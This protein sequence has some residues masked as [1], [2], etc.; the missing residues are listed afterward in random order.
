MKYVLVVVPMD[1]GGFMVQLTPM[2]FPSIPIAQEYAK[3]T[4]AMVAT[5]ERFAEKL[6]NVPGCE[7]H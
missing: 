5:V 1:N 4:M 3:D 2:T 6:N 7:H